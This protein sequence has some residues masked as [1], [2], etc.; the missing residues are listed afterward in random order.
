MFY[1][2]LDE[3]S[4]VN[5]VSDFSLS[6][7]FYSYNLATEFPDCTN[8]VINKN[9]LYSLGDTINLSVFYAEENKFLCLFY[10]FVDSSGMM[11]DYGNCETFVST[12]CPTTTSSP[13]TTIE[14]YDPMNYFLPR[15]RYF[16]GIY[17]TD[18]LY[19]NETMGGDFET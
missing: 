12:I 14:P 3:V 15:D 16:S 1:K 11:L 19:Y 9:Q 10:A 7:D 5:P 13:T 4:E 17:C 18:R 2:S 6:D 8:F